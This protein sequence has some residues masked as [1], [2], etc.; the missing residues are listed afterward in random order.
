MAKAVSL[1]LWKTSVFVPDVALIAI[2]LSK[3]KMEKN[4]A[5]AVASRLSILLDTQRVFAWLGVVTSMQKI[6][7]YT[8][9]VASCRVTEAVVTKTA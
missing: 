7:R 2:F 3:N 1:D 9:A 6:T 8:M 4:S 5:R